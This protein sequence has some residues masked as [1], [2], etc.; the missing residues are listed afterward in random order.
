MDELIT[1]SQTTV[2]LP[3]TM[4]DIASPIF[5]Q[6]RVALLVFVGIFAGAILGAFF[7]PR[8]YES[9][10]KILV[11]RDRVDAPVTPDSNVSEPVTAARAVSE[12]DIN[13]EVELL[14]SDDLLRQVVL[15][16]GL[17]AGSPSPLERIVDRMRGVHSAREASLARAIQ[18]LQNKLVVDP[19]KKTNVIRVAYSSRNPDL[20]ANVLQTL[21]TL[22]QEKHAAV[23][24]PAGTFD[25][26]DQQTD[27]YRD[28][29]AAAETELM[30]FNNRENVV[31][32]ET[33]KQLLLQQL[34][35]FETDLEQ[36]RLNAKAA[37]ERA[38]A[39]RSQEQV[40]PERQ[41]T[42]TRQFENP[43]LLADLESTLLTLELKRNDMLV[44]Y[45]PT[46]PLVVDVDT[47]I[48]S[49][50]Q[51]IAQARSNR[52][53]DTTTDRVPAQDWMATEL[54]K[55]EADSAQFA[56][57]A[58]ATATVV[59]R[60]QEATQLLD[61]K[62][63]MQ[64][65]LSRNVKTAEDNYLLY[66]HKREEARISDALDRKRIVNV[67]I[68]EAAS[69]PAFSTMHLGWLLTAG[70]FA[71]VITGLGAAYTADRLDSSFHTPDELNRYLDI[72]VLASIPASTA[73]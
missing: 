46:Y 52:L 34:A 7:A 16:C 41:V 45:A 50:R 55:A 14:K 71:G 33:Q 60:Y 63:T 47:Q 6:R 36:D 64:A 9:E 19:L 21:A 51:Q 23:H 20:S 39:L 22:Y 67:S 43:Q 53:Q 38:Q 44:K 17:E 37:A 35:Q 72:K 49:A 24:R 18:S 10:M 66:L 11:N 25:F 65:D 31:A 58:A 1:G 54:A 5:R 8:S 62:E 59:H 26:F 13:S 28:Q 29:L 3:R 15:S 48:A 42:Q 32:P 57:H 2:V 73:R 30:N 27:R 4:R 68:A 69:T 40:T 61:Q 12:E 56:A 70:L